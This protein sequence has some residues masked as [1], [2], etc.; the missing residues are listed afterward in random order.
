VTPELRIGDA[1]REAA[2]SALGEHYVAGRLTKEE[3][4]ERCAVAWQAR[5]NAHLVPLFADLPRLHDPRRRPVAP[6]VPG[7]PAPTRPTS[8]TGPRFPLLPVFAILLGIAMLVDN[9]WLVLVVVGVLWWAGL[10]RWLH[11][12]GGHTHQRRRC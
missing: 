6:A 2:V 3:Y 5:T 12:L 9:L 8:R 4:D 1:E 7:V 10:F 11:R